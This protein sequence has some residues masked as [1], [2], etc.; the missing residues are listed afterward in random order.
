MTTTHRSAKRQLVWDHM[1]QLEQDGLGTGEVVS[2]KRDKFL[3]HTTH[4]AAT[5]LSHNIDANGFI[6]A[7]INSLLFR[8]ASDLLRSRLEA[9]KPGAAIR[10]DK[11]YEARWSSLEASDITDMFDAVRAILAQVARK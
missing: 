2:E 11:G 6:R 9:I 10:S 3:L 1:L 5:A 4:G 7:D 8:H